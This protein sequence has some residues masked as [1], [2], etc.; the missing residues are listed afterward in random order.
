MA[1]TQL[2]PDLNIPESQSTVEISVIDTTSHMSGFPSWTFVE[3]HVPGFDEMN[4]GSYSF[5]I[6]HASSVSKYDTLLFDLGVRKDWENCP[7][8]FVEGI[9]QLGSKIEVEKDVA[10]ILRENKQS[11]EEVG[12]IIWSHWHFDHTGDPR[13]FP[14]T[15]DL[16]VGPGFKSHF[17]PAFP[18][19]Q[20]SHVDERAWEGR[21]LRELNFEKEGN[22]LKIVQFQAIDFYNDGS[23]Y[24]LDTPGHTIRH[25]SALAR[26]TA[27]P[28]TFIFMG[29]D[30]AHHGGEFRPSSYMP[31]PQE[32]DLHPLSQKVFG[33]H[34]VCPGELFLSIHP[35]KSRTEPFFNPTTVDGAWHF[36]A[37]EAKQSIEKL[38]E[39]DAYEDIMPII[40][41]DNSMIGIVEFYPKTANHWR[42]KGWKTRSRWGFLKSFNVSAMRGAS[43]R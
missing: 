29:G 27:D 2:P 12:G 9:K 11:L 20:D 40:A 28:P 32:I 37:A 41:H 10:T 42:L 6:K 24:L 8:S 43:G 5:L 33:S 36:C 1:T 16:I 38:T 3:P 4:C 17:V 13:T 14:S 30:I 34:P 15:T 39:F 21:E 25:I 7:T 19:I 26:T 18:T 22:G 23:L 35:N 31:L